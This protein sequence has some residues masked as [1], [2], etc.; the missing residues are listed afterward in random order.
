MYILP[1]NGVIGEDFKMS[2]LLMHLNAAKD[3]K[4]IKL[5]INSPGGYT[6][7][8]EKIHNA[9]KAEKKIYYSTNSGDIAS[10]AVELFLVA[11]KENRTFDP[12]KGIFLIHLPFLD[13][14]DG[15]VTGT[16]EEIQ[17]VAEGMK[18]LEKWT[19]KLY[20]KE[21]GTSANILTGFMKENIPL[22]EE[23]IQTLG[24]ATIIKPTFKAV[25]YF[26]NN[27]DM[28]NKEVKEK[29]TGIEGLLSKIMSFI[30]PKNIMLADVNGVNIDFGAD[31]TDP[32]Q[33]TV[34][35]SATV[36]GAP[37]NG[38]YVMPDGSTLVFAE[39]KLN[40]IVPSQ[41]SEM[42]KL[43]TENEQL[44]QKLSEKDV[45][46]ENF[47]KTANADILNVKNEVLKFR[48]M[49]SDGNPKGNEGHEETDPPVIRKAFKK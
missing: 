7:E 12:T 9:L 8:A 43:K 19:A 23:Q 6:D 5:I 29:L 28:E 1:I 25:A 26:K 49:F 30:R 10:A 20:Q 16:S 47:K 32:S 17:A 4:V 15:G 18:E 2:D 45:E 39:G 35:I 11:P 37:A 46:F 42:Q 31:V 3:E 21:T 38:N 27:N 13:P 14:S 40:E 22:T 33:I 24:F 48:N 44:K 36:D 41:D 34:G